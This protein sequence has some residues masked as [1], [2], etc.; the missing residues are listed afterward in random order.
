MPTTSVSINTSSYTQ[1]NTAKNPIMLQAYGS[2]VRIVFASAQPA[3]N[4][5]NYHV[6][7]PRGAPMINRD[8]DT[9]VWALAASSES[10]LIATESA[11]DIGPELNVAF[12][13]ISGITEKAIYG[14]VRLTDVADNS[15][16]VWAYA[17][18]GAASR[19]DTKPFPTSAATLYIASSSSLDVSKTFTVE[20]ID[21]SGNS[22]N[23]NVTTDA[24]DGQ[25][26]VAFATSA[27]MDVNMVKLT[28]ANQTQVGNIFIC[29]TN[30]FT[31]GVPN[32]PADVLAY[33]TGAY[34]VSQQC[35]YYVPNGYSIRIKRLNVQLGKDAGTTTTGFIQ[36]L[37]KESGK[38]WVTEREYEIQNGTF[39]IFESGLMF[40]SNTRI[41]VRL[42]DV[43]AADTNITVVLAFEL[44]AN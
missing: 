18:D 14:R 35:A 43:I 38:S 9:N 11:K 34:G 41:E 10:I 21:G 26:P 42:R 28:G 19:A 13:K 8:N 7:A 30:S 39:N 29:N 6:L 31:A 23:I 24:S 16:T 27:G 25:T 20:V 17:D 22:S 44:I 12:G 36:L 4:V 40:G 15:V 33:L 37:V 2:F 5:T 1:V 32:T 3:A